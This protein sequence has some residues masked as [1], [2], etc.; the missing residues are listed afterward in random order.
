LP[1]KI[2]FGASIDQWGGAQE[3]KSRFAMS[4]SCAIGDPPAEMLTVM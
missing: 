1:W 3:L 2:C 4:L